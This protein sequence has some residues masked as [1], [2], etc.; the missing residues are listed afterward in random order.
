[1]R[2]PKC[3]SMLPAPIAF[4][5]PGLPPPVATTGALTKETGMPNKSYA[6][7]GQETVA[8]SIVAMLQAVRWSAEELYLVRNENKCW[9]VYLKE[10]R[11]PIQRI[12]VTSDGSY[13]DS[14]SA[15]R[16]PFST[17][18]DQDEW[19]LIEREDRM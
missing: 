5:P 15:Y 10:S 1:M 11:R 7:L 2:Q 6:Q 13:A 9:E 14:R 8:R 12:S 3:K 16:N 17:L 4:D 18:G 19:D